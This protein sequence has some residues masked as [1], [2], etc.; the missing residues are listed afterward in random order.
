[1]HLKSVSKE[2]ASGG[3]LARRRAAI[4]FR[5]VTD[6]A[7]LVDDVNQIF[8]QNRRRRAAAVHAYS[9]SEAVVVI[10]ATADW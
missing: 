9:V 7:F 6:K 3:S 4:L 10:N 1:M 5:D 8:K 2:I